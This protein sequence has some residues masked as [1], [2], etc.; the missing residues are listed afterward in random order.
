MEKYN[1]NPRPLCG[2]RLYDIVDIKIIIQISIHAPCAGGDLHYSLTAGENQ[3]ISIH[4]PCAGGDQ[5]TKI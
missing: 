3:G 4:A 1:F 2:G 5:S